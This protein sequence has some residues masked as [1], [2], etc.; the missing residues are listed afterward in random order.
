MEAP[1]KKI[2]II[3]SIFLLFCFN[4]ESI[5]SQETSGKLIFKALEYTSEA[6]LKK[7]IVKQLE[8]AGI[9]WGHNDTC[10]IVSLVN[11]KY[12]N[13]DLNELTRYGD[14][15][16]VELKP[17]SYT[18][19]CIGYILNSVS[20]DIDVVLSKSAYFNLDILSFEIKS[21]QTTLIEIL[22]VMQKQVKRGFSSGL[23][24]Y[25]PD[26]HTKI[27]ENEKVLAEA[28]I[29]LETDKSIQWDDYNGPLKFK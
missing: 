24:M 13:A 10:L 15:K 26:Y 7:N 20:K 11:R 4:T 1:M 22:P 9:L 14:E 5:R 17:G 16:E 3:T 28:I 29:N 6:K 21:D 12:V 27:I 18:I 23:K 25:L 19:T 2:A 8:H